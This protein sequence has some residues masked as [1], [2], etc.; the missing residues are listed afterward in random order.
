VSTDYGGRQYVGIDLH[1]RRSVIVR[2]TPEGEQLGWVRIDNGVGLR[3]RGTLAEIV[4][5]FAADVAEHGGDPEKVTDTSSDM[6]TAFISG[7][8][9]HLPNATMTFDRYHLPRQAQ[10][11]HRRGAPRGARHSPGAQAYPL[12]VADKPRHPLSQATGGAPP[13][14]APLGAAGHCPGPALA[15]GLPGLL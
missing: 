6:S 14:D 15:T 12:A 3:H 11:G 1:R 8:G 5:R 2:M 9:A 10:R 4:A 7:I 13:A